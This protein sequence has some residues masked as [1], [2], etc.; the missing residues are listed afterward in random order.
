[1]EKWLR[2]QTWGL[3]LQDD[4]GQWLYFCVFCLHSGESTKTLVALLEGFSDKLE[5]YHHKLISY[6]T[7]QLSANNRTTLSVIVY[8]TQPGPFS[9]S[10][11]DLSPLYQ[12][13]G[14]KGE[15]IA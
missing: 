2:V 6:K 11:I 12:I 15:L 7:L 5:T 14:L 8:A 3:T 4:L 9:C 10:P 1:M 13:V